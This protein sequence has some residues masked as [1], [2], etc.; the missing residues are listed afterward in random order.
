M[1]RNAT[2]GFVL[3]TL[4]L[5]TYFYFFAPKPPTPTEN[6][7][8]TEITDSQVSPREVP[9][10]SEA[11]TL[12]Q[13]V[14]DSLEQVA[15]NQTFGEFANLVQGEAK[16]VRIQTDELDVVLNTLG[17]AIQEVYLNN[18][19]TFDSLPLPMIEN[20]PENEFGLLFGYGGTKI[21]TTDLYFQPSLS[22][23]INVSGEDTQELRMKAEVSPGKYIEQ[24]YTFKGKSFDI[25]YR[26]KV[27]GM[28]NLFKNKFYE[29]LWTS[30]LP[31]TE[32]SLENMR[33]KTTLAYNRGGDVEKMGVSEEYEKEDLKLDIRWV[34]FK[35]QFFS[36]ALIAE[37]PFQTASLAMDT[38]LSEEISRMMKADLYVDVSSMQN[39]EQEYTFFM[40]PNEYDLLNS[41]EVGLQKQ[42]D[43]GWSIIR[44][45]NIATIR[46]FK[47]LE[48]YISNYGL[49][50]IL[51]AVIVKIV[52]F[53]FT[54]K[55]FISMA[56]MRVI[57]QT[58]EIKSLDDKYKDDMQKLQME[59][60]KVYRETGV[61]MFGGC[62][63]MLL[64]YPF[65]I[66]LFFF[67]PQSVELRQKSF[68]WAN[69]LSTYDSVLDLP[70]NIPFYGDHVSL[71]T[72]L[73]AVSIMVFTYFQQKSQPTS[74]QQ[75]QLKYI[76]YFM[77]VIFLVFLNNYASGLSLYYFTSNLLSISQTT[78]SRY[79][80]NDEKLLAQLR[81]NQKKSKKKNK[82]GGK[83]P[84]GRIAK[85]MEEQQ[86]K[87]QEVLKQ[88]QNAQGKGKG[89]RQTRRK[90]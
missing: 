69:D 53:P 80:I 59:K 7:S 45:V 67:F 46:I 70:F 90:N 79:F 12:P 41:Y 18:Y 75:E 84:K 77:P 22:G 50:V 65:L 40:G 73:M 36:S 16:E 34:S 81:E 15:L 57:N 85:W 1:D 9:T 47:F 61:S 60:M 21:N 39:S 27:E 13:T 19:L 6:L 58:P 38:P 11:D 86:K 82:K 30:Y 78:A 74:P 52:V 72:I 54:F 88:R 43:L 17:G 5:I 42:M 23:P 55:S 24:I 25:G 33:Q 71:F 8:Q 14:K 28:Q 3:I 31:K 26:V 68:L 44:Y 62:L 10:I 35:S 32:L 49:I 64:S 51:L 48:K 63:P 66:A 37:E 76:Q 83:A 89:N 20:N 4:L 87:Q 56:K 2:T 29:I